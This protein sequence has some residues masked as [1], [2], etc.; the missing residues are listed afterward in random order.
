MN[1]EA[2]G[3][4]MVALEPRPRPLASRLLGR[5]SEKAH[6]GLHLEI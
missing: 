5:A 6:G 1:R 2:T 3:A 4:I